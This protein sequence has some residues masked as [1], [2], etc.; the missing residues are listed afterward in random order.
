M[1]GRVRQSQDQA[2]AMTRE[3]DE[4]KRERINNS[5]TLVLKPK[6]A[7]SSLL[8]HYQRERSYDENAV[9]P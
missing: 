9:T 4:V 2:T 7:S 5:S 1:Q 6:V 3:N 8:Y